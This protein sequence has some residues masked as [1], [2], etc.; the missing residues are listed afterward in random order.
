ME[1]ELNDLE[2]EMFEV[3]EDLIGRE[4]DYQEDEDFIVK[5]KEFNLVVNF[6]VGINGE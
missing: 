2:S 1:I 6:D 4:V 5:F 3:T